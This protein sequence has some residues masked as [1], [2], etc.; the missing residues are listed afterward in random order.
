M[1]CSGDCHTSL[2]PSVTCYTQ[3]WNN[4][5]T[6]SS[7]LQSFCIFFLVFI[8]CFAFVVLMVVGKQHLDALPPLTGLECGSE[9]IWFRPLTFDRCSHN[10][11]A[12]TDKYMYRYTPWTFVYYRGCVHHVSEFTLCDNKRLWSLR[13]SSSIR[14]DPCRDW[15]IP[16]LSQMSWSLQM[17]NPMRES[18]W[19]KP[20]GEHH[21]SLTD[22]SWSYEF[23]NV[24]LSP[25]V[26]NTFSLLLSIFYIV[27]LISSHSTNLDYI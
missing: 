23:F 3:L 8:Y 6:P 4:T 27:V 1:P 24:W 5:D 10:F 11:T 18:P 12:C 14:M 15:S 17:V 2:L 20:R 26:C 7:L 25:P 16:H 19:S 22:A 9:Q 21:V 13:S